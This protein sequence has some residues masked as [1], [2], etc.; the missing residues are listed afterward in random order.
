MWANVMKVA[1][2][3]SNNGKT[4][5]YCLP[6]GF[7][8]LI[9]FAWCLFNFTWPFPTQYKLDWLRQY[10]HILI[11]FGYNSYLFHIMWIQGEQQACAAHGTKKALFLFEKSPTGGSK[12]FFLGTFNCNNLKF[13]EFKGLSLFDGWQKFGVF[14]W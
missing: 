12:K 6:S 7:A 1:T 13:P 14:V 9:N 10:F 5:T 4:L 2:F 8:A 3:D 11:S